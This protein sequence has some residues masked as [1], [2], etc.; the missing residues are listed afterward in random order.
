MAKKMLSCCCPH[1][2]A[3]VCVLTLYN[4][5]DMS[6]GVYSM[7]L[8]DGEENVKVLLRKSPHFVAIVCVLT[9]YNVCRIVTCK[10]M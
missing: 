9:L 5:S 10:C 6:I 1:F 3:I 7:K 8:A 4:V 2:V